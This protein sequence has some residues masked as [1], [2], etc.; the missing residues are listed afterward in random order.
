[1]LGGKSGVAN[2]VKLGERARLGALSGATEDI[3]A[4]ATYLGQPAVPAKEFWRQMA[5][6]R[7]LS[8]RG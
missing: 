6:L 2:H 7:R 5:V 1:M 8:K 4:G 3:E